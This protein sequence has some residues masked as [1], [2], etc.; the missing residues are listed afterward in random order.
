[1]SRIDSI[2]FIRKDRKILLALAIIVFRIIPT[3]SVLSTGLLHNA[4]F[5]APV[6]SYFLDQ[7]SFFTCFD[8]QTHEQAILPLHDRLIRFSVPPHGSK[9]ALT[10][11]PYICLA[12]RDEL[13]EGPVPDLDPTVGRLLQ[14]RKCRNHEP[15]RLLLALGLNKKDS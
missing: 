5:R 4:M 12:P 2:Y 14:T 9:E 8:A 7:N 11:P 6:C 3:C 10:Q 13:Q 1:M 15:A